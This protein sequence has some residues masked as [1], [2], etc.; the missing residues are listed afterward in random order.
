[1]STIFVASHFCTLL[2]SVAM[3]VGDKFFFRS[4]P[5]HARSRPNQDAGAWVARSDYDGFLRYS[6][7]LI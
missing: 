4:G 6:Y 5:S 1:M 2:A 7:G 3:Q